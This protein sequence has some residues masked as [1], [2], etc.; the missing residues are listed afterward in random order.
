MARK[1]IDKALQGISG[2]HIIKGVHV[3]DTVFIQSANIYY[4]PTRGLLNDGD[5]DISLS[6]YFHEFY[7]NKIK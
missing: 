4:T 2:G 3:V 1:L 7:P 5:R 6:L